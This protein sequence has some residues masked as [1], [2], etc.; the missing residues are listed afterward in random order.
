MILNSSKHRSCCQSNWNM[1]L[2]KTWYKIL[3][4]F[5]TGIWETPAP[6]VTSPSLCIGPNTRSGRFFSSRFGVPPTHHDWTWQ[7]LQVQLRVK[8]WERSVL[9]VFGTQ[10]YP[11]KVLMWHLSSH[12][13]IFLPFFFLQTCKNI[14]ADWC[15]LQLRAKVLSFTLQPCCHLVDLSLPLFLCVASY[16]LL[17]LI[18]AIYVQ[19]LLVWILQSPLCIELYNHEYWNH[20][21]WLL[22]ISLMRIKN[23]LFPYASLSKFPFTLNSFHLDSNLQVSL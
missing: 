12:V 4:S 9:T 13:P 8:H 21:I 6:Y 17:L 7:C 5:G 19:L 16:Y 14:S 10:L 1:L 3:P 11:P 20:S 23:E 18:R 22:Y 15:S 2:L